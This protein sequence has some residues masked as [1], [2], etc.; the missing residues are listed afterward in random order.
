M[1]DRMCDLTGLPIGSSAC[2]EHKGVS[3]R[4][5]MSSATRE[6]R[7]LR[8]LNCHDKSLTSDLSYISSFLP[9][10]RVRAHELRQKS[11]TDLLNQ[12][13]DVKAELAL[14]RV[15]KVA[16]GASNKLSKINVVRLLIAQVLTVIS[17]KQKAAL[18]EA[19][20]QEEEIHSSRS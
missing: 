15:A 19:S 6:L 2:E 12:F 7:N 3:C 9:A 11:K 1:A 10:A 18:R 5:R 13:N 14:L 16:G 8:I 20:L 4:S 17:Q